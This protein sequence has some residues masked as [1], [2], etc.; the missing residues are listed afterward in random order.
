M[1]PRP[2]G[3][4]SR[5]VITTDAGGE[6]LARQMGLMS[7]ENDRRTYYSILSTVGKLCDRYFPH[8]REMPVGRDAKRPLYDEALR[9]QPILNMYEDA[10]PIS[11]M[12][13]IHRQARRAGCRGIIV[14]FPEAPTIRARAR[15]D[16]S[17]ASVQHTTHA[18]VAHSDAANAKAAAGAGKSSRVMETF[19]RT[20]PQDL[21]DLLPVFIQYGVDDDNALRGMLRM[22]AWQSWLY[23][24]VKEGW[25]TEL[26][27]RMIC[28]GLAQIALG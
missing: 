16:A 2:V 21:G 1:I 27:F 18:P 13:N 15:N 9:R 6:C 23:S 22:P 10:W 8:D 7:S 3:P 26:Q 4:I 14:P 5:R 25:L 24:W 17:A 28:N 20:L 11:T 12:L 19:L